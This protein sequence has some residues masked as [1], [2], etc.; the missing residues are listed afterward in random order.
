MIGGAGDPEATDL[1]DED[2]WRV[3]RR[4]V[5]ELVGMSGDPDFLRVYRWHRGIPQYTLGHLDRRA[6]LEEM[7]KHRP[8]LYLVGN[9]YYGVGLNDCV[10][11]AHRIA[12]DIRASE[13]R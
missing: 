4:E 12:G 9:A 11:M 6:R 1:S 3:V 10:K 5:G 7:A 2:L 13:I 8:G